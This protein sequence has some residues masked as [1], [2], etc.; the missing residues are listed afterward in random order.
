VQRVGG[1]TRVGHLDGH[2]QVVGAALGVSDLDDPVPVLVERPGVD[3][4][5]LRLVT[6]PRAVHVDQFLV[7]VRALRVVVAPG[8]PGMARYRVQV[9]PVLLDILAVIALPA[10]QPE[11]PLLQDRVATVPQRKPEAQ[12]LFH[13]AE[14]GQAV[15]A[16][17]VGARPGVIVRQVVPCLAVG[18]VVLPYRP[19]LPLA[20]VRPPPVPVTGLAQ[21]VFHPAE[22]GHPFPLSAHRSPLPLAGKAVSPRAGRP[23]DHPGRVKHGAARWRPGKSCWPDAAR[24]S[25][26]VRCLL[27]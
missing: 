27:A 23:A 20:D 12:P 21:P 16:P 3:Q 5:V 9:P 1:G 19:P 4:L 22:P 11:G 15:L 7:R 10:G 24:P 8:V 14:S 18:A 6:V 26:L 2:Q 17:A 25:T 13:V